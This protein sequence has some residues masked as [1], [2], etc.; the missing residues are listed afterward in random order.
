MLELRR[1][2]ESSGGWPPSPGRPALSEACAQ[3]PRPRSDVDKHGERPRKTT[4]SD[5]EEDHEGF[6]GR[7]AELHISGCESA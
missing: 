5:E 3:T 2:P 6:G 1:T 4:E 7:F